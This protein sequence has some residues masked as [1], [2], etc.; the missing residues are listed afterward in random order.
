MILENSILFFEGVSL[1]F[2]EGDL[3]DFPQVF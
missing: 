3:L 2:A 1:S